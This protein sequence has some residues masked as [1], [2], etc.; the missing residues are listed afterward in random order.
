MFQIFPDEGLR[1]Y[2]WEH[3]A[4]TLIGNNRNQKFNIYTGSG[5]N[6][7]SK[8]INL[9]NMC[10]GDYADKLNIALITQKEKQLVV[11]LQK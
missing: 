2:M 4:S 3:T 7:K 6:G 5:G 9:L 8:Y 1:R 11:L 10:L